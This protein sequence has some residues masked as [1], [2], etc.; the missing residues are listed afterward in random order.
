MNWSF[1][2]ERM[3]KEC[4]RKYFY[5][6]IIPFYTAE[7][8]DENIL[9]NVLFLRKLTN[10]HLLLG[11]VIHHI[12]SEC[13]DHFY[14]NHHIPLAELIDKCWEKYILNLQFS[15]AQKYLFFPDTHP[16]FTILFEDIYGIALDDNW[17]TKQY[18]KMKTALRYFFRWFLDQ[19]SEKWI[20]FEPVE[21][22]QL[23]S[24]INQNVQVWTVVD[25]LLKSPQN[26]WYLI[27]WK[28]SVFDLEKDCRQLAFY[29]LYVHRIYNNSQPLKLIN[30][31]LTAGYEHSFMW[32]EQL[33]KFS[34]IY[35][36][37][38]VRYF[39]AFHQKL[40]EKYPFQNLQT[41]VKKQICW[42]CNF[43]KI[44]LSRNSI[45]QKLEK[46]NHSNQFQREEEVPSNWMN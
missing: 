14:K 9:K 42:Q 19:E 45:I 41:T 39:Q 24:F 18:Q 5:H 35:F 33:R 32:D 8:I 26:G 43:K 20:D 38:S 28:L 44:C 2:R 16:D 36:D 46:V 17:L 12:I 22:E 4:E 29:G 3:L 13:I 34:E 11:K 25:L 30:F 6:Y 37:K 27:D 7:Q 23:K 40:N 31:Y 1:S 10:R 15:H 21:K